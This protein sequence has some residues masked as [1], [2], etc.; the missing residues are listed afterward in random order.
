M[1]RPPRLALSCLLAASSGHLP[2]D[3]ELPQRSGSRAPPTVSL[4]FRLLTDWRFTRGV[5][6]Q[7]KAFLDGFNEVAPLEWLRYFDEKELEVRAE[8]V[9]TLN[10]RPLGL[11]CPLIALP[12]THSNSPVKPHALP[13]WHQQ[14]HTVNLGL[15]PA[16]PWALVCKG[17]SCKTWATHT[18]KTAD[19]DVWGASSCQ[20]VDGAV[21]AVRTGLVLG[22]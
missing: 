9:G 10:P 22:A 17:L 16:L 21:C 19:R 3:P 13:G 4:G 2:A 5:E 1:S 15:A 14:A 20:G 18:V 11:S 6:E 12:I 7:T 8:I